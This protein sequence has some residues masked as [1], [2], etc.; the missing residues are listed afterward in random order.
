M[1]TK[2]ATASTL[3]CIGDFLCQQIEKCKSTHPQFDRNTLTDFC[4]L[5]VLHSLHRKGKNRLVKTQKLHELWLCGLGP[6]ALLHIQQDLA[7]HRTGYEQYRHH[8]EDALHSD[9]LHSGLNERLLHCYPDNAREGPSRGTE[10][11]STQ[12]VAHN[13]DQLEGLAHPAVHQLHIRAY[14]AAGGLCR[15][16]Q[17]LFQHLLELYEVRV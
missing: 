5:S 8:Q 13:E 11:D 4:A 7:L 10:G 1:L 15:I 12:T 9:S 14:V 6:Y 16:L 3:M 2:C 17:P